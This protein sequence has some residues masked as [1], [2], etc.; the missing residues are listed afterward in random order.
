M[1]ITV[2]VMVAARPSKRDVRGINH[3]DVFLK[4]GLLGSEA[5]HSYNLQEEMQSAMRSL[6]TA[7]SQEVPM[8]KQA[9]V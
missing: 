4:K 6:L 2:R 1:R 8:S 7:V 9:H 5:R 3:L